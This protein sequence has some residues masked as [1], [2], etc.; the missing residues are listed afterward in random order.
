[1]SGVYNYNNNATIMNCTFKDNRRGI[2]NN[3][4]EP[5]VINCMFSSNGD[6]S[7]WGGGMYNSNSISTVINCTF[8]GNTAARGGGMKNDTNSDVN[9]INSVFWG[10]T[11]ISEGNEISN[12]SSTTVI[13]F[14]DIAD[15][16]G[17]GGSWDTSLGA[18]GGGN[19]DADPFFVD[20]DSNNLRLLGGSPCIDSGN[21][22]NVPAGIIIDLDGRG[23]FIDDILTVDDGNVVDMG[24]YEY[25]IIYVN[26][27]STSGTNTGEN[28]DNAFVELGDA[29]TEALCGDSIWVAEGTYK[30]TN[31]VEGTDDRYKT[32]QMKNGVEIY[33]GFPNDVNTAEFQ[34]RDSW[35]YE[36]VLSGDIGTIDDANDNCYHV[37]YHPAG[38][39]LDE[40][41]VLDGF[42]ITAGHANDI[43][44]HPFDSGGGMYNDGSSPTVSNCIFSDNF[45]INRGG[46]MRNDN[47]SVPVIINSAFSGNS[48]N[49]YGGG[50]YNF[51]YSGP[52]FTNCVFS[53]NSGS[54]G[55][56][57][58]NNISSPTV[59]NCTFSN[60]TASSYGGGIRNWG[61]ASQPTVSNSIFWG[62]T[63]TTGPQI[64]DN[65]G[66]VTTASYSDIQGGWTGTG[67]INS[68]PCFVDANG[69]D[70][71]AGTEDDNLKL[72][73]GSPCIDTGNNS[74][75]MELTDIDGQTR[76]IDGDANGTSIVDMGAY[77]RQIIIYVDKDVSGGRNNG[78]SWSN[79]FDDLQKALN[80]A[81]LDNQIWVAEGT[82]YPS[83]KVDGTGDRHK[84]FQ[85]INGVKI[86][87]GFAG[88]ETSSFD[89]NDRDFTA[90]ETI[91]SGDIGSISDPNDNCYHVFCHPSGTALDTTAILDGFTITG[92]YADGS[93]SQGEATGAGMYNYTSSPT[94]SNCTF[95]DNTAEYGGGIFNRSSSS[96]K[97]ENCNFIYNVAY[98]DGGYGEGGGMHNLS[99]SYPTVINC[100]FRA[101]YSNRRGGAICNKDNS[102]AIITNCTF[103]SNSTPGTG[104]TGGGIYI[105]SSD[106]TVKNCIFWENSGYDGQAE[107]SQIY[108]FSGSA[109]VS[110]SCLQG[111]DTF[112]GNNNI[113][114]DPLLADISGQIR[115][116]SY[117][118]C[119]NAGD[120]SGSYTGQTDIDG[121]LRVRYGRV[122]IGADEVF[123]I[124]GDF[125]EPDTPDEDVDY[126]D[127]RTFADSWL[128]ETFPPDRDINE[129]FEVNF[130]DFA[131]LCLNWL[132]G[133]D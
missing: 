6:H 34:D 100:F 64:D 98:D 130:E 133:V 16:N 93:F 56:G 83:V 106:I 2:N 128:A 109:T 113:G 105:D 92:G 63:A 12:D 3:E 101:N 47:N 27:D 41:A 10:N 78:S 46:G 129:D 8:V 99:N 26:A 91:L 67:N 118:P 29:L 123:P 75:V 36:T 114:T 21:D 124:A 13:S 79:A 42:T 85:M 4:S 88:N 66:A 102:D 7:V 90:N 44:T 35:V 95:T 45:A 30:P 5:V 55:G 32:F 18:D 59:T 68:D 112:A 71:I 1:L 23:R 80:E 61:A 74:I 107:S 72:I 43:T 104:G 53:G 15:S 69:L 11:A 77:E 19:I 65:S 125:N 120:P 131:Y 33:G 81:S 115:L 39:D 25:R 116:R 96:P 110:Y 52:I 86:Y 117:S 126:F 48:A 62:N 94:L 37:F 50:I 119:I 132:Y 89:I 51:N 22:G 103:R 9:V 17:S 87:G 28:W 111:L 127:L 73:G 122:D 20:A 108:V 82:Y 14:C 31:E 24:A 40:G 60:N 121:E 70:N 54:R 38:T 76:I 57:I 58:Y 84:S 49:S 97:V